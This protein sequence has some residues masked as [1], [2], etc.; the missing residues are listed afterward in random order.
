[1]GAERHTIRTLTPTPHV[2][3]L[4]DVFRALMQSTTGALAALYAYESRVPRIAELKARTLRAQ[5][6]ANGKTCHYFDLHA[7]MDVHHS[8]VWKRQLGRIL[9]ETPSLFAE[10]EEAVRKA[11][12]ALCGALDG[13]EGSRQERLRHGA[14]GSRN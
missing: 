7:T 3:A 10:A 4:I 2:Q 11:S 13:I 8:L 9:S 14:V 1:M 5:Y 12:R 6:G